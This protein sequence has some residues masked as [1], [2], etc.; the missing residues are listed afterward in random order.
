MGYLL[1]LN[2]NSEQK[3]FENRLSE[4]AI[5]DPLTGCY[6]R[7][8]FYEMAQAYFSQMQRST[9]PL[10]V[11]MIDLD[12]FKNINDTYGHAQGDR[13]LQKVAAACKSRIRGPDVFA[14]YGGEEFVMVLPETDLPD[15][16]LVA[17]RLRLAIEQLRSELDDIPVSA[18]IGVAMAAGETGMT[19][20]VLLRR[21][22]E[23]MYRSK[24]AGR[25]Q[26]TVWEAVAG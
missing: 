17:E 13:V 23:A 7:R 2:N 19:L 18:S 12:H 6:N 16:Q 9:R 3:N 20:E 26:V 1:T 11:V 14:R 22:D 10:S 5:S 25:N 4:L 15:A 21:A 8:Y 24:Q